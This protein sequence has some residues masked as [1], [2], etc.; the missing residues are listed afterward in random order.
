MFQ[1]RAGFC[2]V[3]LGLFEGGGGDPQGA[4]ISAVFEAGVVRG[5]GGFGAV[6][7]LLD[8]AQHEVEL[9]EAGEEVD[10]VFEEFSLFIVVAC[11]VVDKEG[12]LAWWY[13][14]VK[15]GGI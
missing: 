4:A 12:G 2:K 3:L 13:R 5:S 15:G 11:G 10:A 6:L 1:Q 8:L 7:A 9:E 14:M